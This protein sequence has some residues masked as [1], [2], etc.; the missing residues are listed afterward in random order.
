VVAVNSPEMLMYLEDRAIVSSETSV[1]Q[2]IETSDSSET[3]VKPEHG[4]KWFA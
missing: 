4:G 2:K 1:N 3:L